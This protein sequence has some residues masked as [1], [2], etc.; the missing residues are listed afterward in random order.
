RVGVHIETA[1]GAAAERDRLQNIVNGTP[2]VVIV[3]T[4]ADGRITLFNPGAELLL[5]YDAAEVMGRNT[6]MFHTPL[7]VSEKAAEL[8]VADDFAAVARRLSD[9]DV[10]PTEIRW[11]RKDGVERD[12]L[13]TLSRISDERGEVLGYV[14][15]S[16][17]VTERLQVQNALEEAL[18]TERE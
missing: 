4:A 7:M 13:M 1:R 2:G 15:T 3:G 8:G 16:E 10:G 9:P 14:C 5:G 17:D 18:A 11:V 6:T 12:H